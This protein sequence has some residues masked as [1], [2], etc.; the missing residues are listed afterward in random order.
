MQT[1][2]PEPGAHSEEDR[3]PT[4]EQCEEPTVGLGAPG[5]EYKLGDGL[6]VH[7]VC[8]VL[9]D[10]A[11]ILKPLP[12]LS[13]NAS[14]SFRLVLVAQS[15]RL[16]EPRVRDEIPDSSGVLGAGWT[17]E[18][19]CQVVVASTACLCPGERTQAVQQ[20]PW[21]TD[22]EVPA[23]G[24]CL[25]VRNV[26]FS[27]ESRLARVSLSGVSSTFCCQPTRMGSIQ[28]HRKIVTRRSRA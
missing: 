28:I 17:S 15:P 12:L 4:P 24:I 3:T 13:P 19:R 9:P 25:A 26:M 10:G 11:S 16:A 8:S 14:D 21:S 6:R 22:A 18:R 20:V 27:S 7:F 2:G 1:V 5:C 23:A